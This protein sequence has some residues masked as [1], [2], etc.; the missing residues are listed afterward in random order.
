VRGLY[1]ANP[2]GSPPIAFFHCQAA[3][4]AYGPHPIHDAFVKTFVLPN[5]DS[6]DDTIVLDSYTH[7]LAGPARKSKSAVQVLVGV[8]G[9]AALGAVLGFAAAHALRRK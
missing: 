2:I 6:A 9:I 4:D 8:V 3:L 5:R 1:P 7:W